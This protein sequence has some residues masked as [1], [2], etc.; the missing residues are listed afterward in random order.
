MTSTVPETPAGVEQVIVV[1]FTTLKEPTHGLPAPMFAA[2]AP[3]KL[4]PVMVIGVPPSV[5]PLGGETDVTKGCA[6]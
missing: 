6:L 4:E 5:E 1:S 2:V 3:V